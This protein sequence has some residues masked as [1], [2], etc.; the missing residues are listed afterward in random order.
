MR[1]LVLYLNTFELLRNIVEVRYEFLLFSFQ[2]VFRLSN[3]FLFWRTRS[4]FFFS[5][6]FYLTIMRPLK[7]SSRRI[8]GRIGRD[9][10]CYAMP[11]YKE[12]PEKKINFAIGISMRFLERENHNI[13]FLY[14]IQTLTV[15]LVF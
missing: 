11:M 14:R 9:T 12:S 4:S 2:I 13:V 7:K 15:Y 3:I 10:F 6:A 8:Y 5:V 1:S